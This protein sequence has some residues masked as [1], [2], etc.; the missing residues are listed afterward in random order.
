MLIAQT[1]YYILLPP[2]NDLDLSRYEAKIK[3]SRDWS[4]LWYRDE[5]SWN[6]N[7]SRGWF[8]SQGTRLICPLLRCWYSH[9]SAQTAYWLTTSKAMLLCY[10]PVHDLSFATCCIALHDLGAFDTDKTTHRA[11]IGLAPSRGFPTT[12]PTHFQTVVLLSQKHMM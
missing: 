4:Y 5:G 11:P 1:V 3:Y 10:H 6:P 2:Q 12:R 7:A 8:S 9:C